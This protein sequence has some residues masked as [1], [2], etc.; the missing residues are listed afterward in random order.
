M[1]TI[2]GKKNLFLSE[3]NQYVARLLQ[4]DKMKQVELITSPDNTVIRLP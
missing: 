1:I 4:G 3:A 2:N